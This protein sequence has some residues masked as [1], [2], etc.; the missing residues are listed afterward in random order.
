[1]SEWLVG[2]HRR[3]AMLSI[4]RQF[5]KKLSKQF[6]I[7]LYVDQSNVVSDVR[8]CKAALIIL[9]SHF[10]ADNETNNNNNDFSCRNYKD[11]FVFARERNI[12]SRS[13]KCSIIVLIIVQLG[14][15]LVGDETNRMTL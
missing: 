1:M 12:R 5:I 2:F 6:L 15:V 11:K 13:R 14:D 8:G 9:L 3:R 4:L 10:E 7:H